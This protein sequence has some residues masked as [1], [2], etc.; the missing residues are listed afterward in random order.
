MQNTCKTLEGNYFDSKFKD[1]VEKHINNNTKIFNTLNDI[2]DINDE[3]TA[4]D[5]TTDDETNNESKEKIFI[6][7]NI[8]DI[9]THIMSIPNKAPGD[10]IFPQHLKHSTEKLFEILAIIY[11]NSVDLGYFPDSWKS[12]LITM[13]LKPGKPAS[14]PSSYR[15]IS[16]LLTLL[17]L[18]ERIM[19]VKI[20]KYMIKNNLMNKFQ[21]G[22]RKGKSCTHQLLR[23]SEHISTWFNKRPTGRTVAIF[24]DAEKAFDTVWHDGLRKMLHDSNI[25]VKIIRWISSF[26]RNRRGKVKVNNCISKEVFL[27]AGVPQGSILSPLL[28]IFYIKD[29]P[30]TISEEIISSFYADDTA[31]A[32]SDNEHKRRK[33]FVSGY[34][35]PI[36]NQLEVFC[37]KWHIGL[38]PD[39]T[40]CMNF[41]K[42]TSNNNTPRLYM[43][44]TL[45][46]TKH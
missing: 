15:P 30:S 33:N 2:N 26:L 40:W 19:I 18:S 37:K 20:T 27:L 28:Y 31:Y 43:G 39:K 38:K 16:L 32:A 21:A 35:Q 11:N 46:C 22:F 45:L 1:E 7:I 24:I 13:I 36:L 34:L 10:K 9:K 42:N 29:M 23:L 4:N 17:K 41:F 44:T 14:S 3:D 25:P 12:S 5:D 6:K 8:K